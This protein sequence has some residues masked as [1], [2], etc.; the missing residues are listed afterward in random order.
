MQA[1]ND[2]G[3]MSLIKKPLS[4]ATEGLRRRRNETTVQVN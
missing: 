2:R 4:S 3:V 1:D